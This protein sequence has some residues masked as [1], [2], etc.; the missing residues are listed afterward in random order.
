VIITVAGIIFTLLSP[1]LAVYTLLGTI[2]NFSGAAGDLWVAQRLLLQPKDG[3]VED[4]DAGYRVWE[5]G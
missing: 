1:A 4:T 5:I 3:L 2:G